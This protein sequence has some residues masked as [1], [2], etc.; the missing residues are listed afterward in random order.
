MSGPLSH[1]WVPSSCQ[2]MEYE[3]LLLF[4][5]Q[6]K[7]FWFFT[8]FWS[9]SFLQNMIFKWVFCFIKNVAFSDGL[10]VMLIAWKVK[11]IEQYVQQWFLTQV[12]SGSDLFYGFFAGK[13]QK[14]RCLDFCWLLQELFI[15][16]QSKSYQGFMMA[17]GMP[18]EAI[19]SFSRLRSV[20][21]SGP[22][23]VLSGRRTIFFH[24]VLPLAINWHGSY[25]LQN[26]FKN[27]STITFQ[28]SLTAPVT[29]RLR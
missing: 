13:C 6:P 14:K 21:E 4:N 11:V 17:T 15:R 12:L 25:H 20:L 10:K 29:L 1:V 9:N 8:I 5:F 7:I 16:K 24:F 3:T 23:K 2:A 27:L 22:A 18:E 28:P 19:Q 26:C